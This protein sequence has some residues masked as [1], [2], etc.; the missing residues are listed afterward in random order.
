MLTHGGTFDHAAWLA[1]TTLVIAQCVRAYA[2]R[3]LREPIHRL[4]PNGFLMLACLG[5][6]AIQALIPYVP[7]VADAFH[8]TPLD[9]Q[10]WLLV[11]GVAFAPAVAAEIVR[12]RGRGQRMWVA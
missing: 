1:Y 8:A 12:W 5:A 6:A 10:D 11:L 3:S 7:G 9:A 4:R 2:N